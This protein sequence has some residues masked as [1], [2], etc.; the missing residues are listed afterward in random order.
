MEQ[1]ARASSRD[2]AIDGSEAHG[3]FRRPTGAPPPLPKKIGATGVFRLALVVLVVIPGCIWLHYNPAPLD[4]FDAAITDALV[5]LRAG[6]LDTLARSVDAAASRYGLA[7]LGLLTVV[8]VAWFRRWRH[9]TLFL[10]GVAVVGVSVEGLLLL[11]ARP[12]PF[13]VTIIGAW[14]G[15]SAPSGPIGG[16]AVVIAGMVYMLVVPGR[17]RMYAKYLGFAVL[18]AAA[19]LRVYLGIDHFTD[20]L[21]GVIIGISIPVAIFRAWAPNDVYPVQYGRHAKAAHLDVTGRRGEAIKLAMKEQLGYD[22][23][24]PTRRGRSAT[25]SRSCT[26]RTMCGRTAG[27]SSD[28]RCSTVASRTRL[29]SARYGASSSTRTTRCDSSARKASRP[30]SRSTSSR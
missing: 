7:L 17:P 21:F 22:V 2:G 15:Y 14:E 5:S 23:L 4:R 20:A 29:P 27:T 24:R 11:A 3:R 16:L 26:P 25:S 10:V 1:R 9:L 18:L 6:W 19:L 30:P 12:R 28:A 8:G 13:D